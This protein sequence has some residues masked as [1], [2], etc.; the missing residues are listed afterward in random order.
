[1]S[2]IIN[3]LVEHGDQ[4]LSGLRVTLLL[5]GKSTEL[6]DMLKKAMEEASENLEF[7]RAASLRDQIR[8]IEKTVEKQAIALWLYSSER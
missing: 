7:E 6:V 8:A 2:T 4:F 5:S 1:M 3:L